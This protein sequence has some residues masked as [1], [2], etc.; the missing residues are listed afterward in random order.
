MREAQRQ[1]PPLAFLV[2]S[3]SWHHAGVAGGEVRGGEDPPSSIS[4]MSEAGQDSFRET[5]NTV[6]LQGTA[7]SR[8]VCTNHGQDVPP[9]HLFS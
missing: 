6:E 2:V 1:S 9:A 7:G 3:T 8:L 5:Q 4:C